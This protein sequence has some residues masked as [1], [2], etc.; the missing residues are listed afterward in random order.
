MHDAGIGEGRV[1]S[2]R[3]RKAEL[4]LSIGL[5]LVVIGA[6]LTIPFVYES[7]SLWYKFGID[8]ELLLSGQMVGLVTAI[9]LNC[10]VLLAA[11][12]PF[13]DRLLGLDRVY[14]LHRCNG[15]AILALGCSHAV[16]VLAPE[17]LR[18]LPIG[19]KYW[20]ELVGAGLLLLLLLLVAGAWGRTWFKLPYS[21]WRRLH[22]PLGYSA[23]GL[24]A[25]HASK[26][27]DSFARPVPRAAL[28]SM[29]LLVVA[30]VV[31]RKIIR[32]HRN[33]RLPGIIRQLTRVGDAITALTVELPPQRTFRYL[34]GQFVF[35]GLPTALPGE[36]HPFTIV[37]TPAERGGLQFMIKASGDWTSGIA[38][39]SVG[40]RVWLD[41]PFGLFNHLA[42]DVHDEVILVAGGIGITPMLGML[43]YMA[44]SS[45]PPR[46]TLIWSNRDE[47][48]MFLGAELDELLRAIPTSTLHLVYTR[49]S[50]GGG[51]L[52][53]ER[54]RTLVGNIDRSARIFL[55][56][57]ASMMQDLSRA[58]RRLGF[59]GRNIYSEKFML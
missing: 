4:F 42:R 52:D 25:V 57:P 38:G 19:W 56:G 41:G 14:L 3:R 7:E 48:D 28:W 15:L 59:S 9:L 6:A 13:F 17:G 46:S 40:Q 50:D 12:L 43:R 47:K 32:W 36:P 58:F 26:V 53:Q 23:L 8:R 10:Q 44:N 45:A 18:N 21:L 39:V 33:R 20:P 51:R 5:L 22:R 2:A 11:R 31:G 24:L 1:V 27:S 54:L 35:L 34:P 49:R 16:L 37:S 29:L 30:T 55:C